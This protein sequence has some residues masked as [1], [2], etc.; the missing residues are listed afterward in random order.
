MS[1]AESLQCDIMT[2]RSSDNAAKADID[3]T[4]NDN[5]SQQTDQTDAMPA[6]ESIDNDDLNASSSSDDE[7]ENEL[8]TPAGA[9]DTSEPLKAVAFRSYTP[10]DPELRK[11]SDAKRQQ[12]LQN[13]N[14]QQNSKQSNSDSIN[15]NSSHSA[16]ALLLDSEQW[17]YSQL[18]SMI[19]GMSDESRLPLTVSTDVEFSDW[20]RFAKQRQSTLDMQTKSAMRKLRKQIRDQEK[21]GK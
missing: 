2:N 9:S 21:N 14:Q 15:A 6:S 18:Q 7:Y 8:E 5:A 20:H 17:L 19:A 16:S 3:M 1:A 13:H 11:A 12:Q 4:H 10:R